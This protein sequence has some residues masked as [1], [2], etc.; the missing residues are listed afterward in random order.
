TGDFAKVQI[1]ARIAWRICRCGRRFG[2]LAVKPLQALPQV[3]RLIQNDELFSRI[4]DSVNGGA[5][6]E[7]RK[8]RFRE[9]FPLIRDGLEREVHLKRM[10]HFRRNRE[11]SSKPPRAYSSSISM[12]YA[13]VVLGTARKARSRRTTFR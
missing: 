1:R 2:T 13:Y 7:C 4:E 3:A 6:R 9:A 8:H 10:Y 5:G 11:T 12:R